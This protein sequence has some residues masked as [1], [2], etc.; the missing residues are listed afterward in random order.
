MDRLKTKKLGSNKDGSLLAF[1]ARPIIFEYRVAEEESNALESV[2]WRLFEQVS[3]N[4]SQS[5][6]N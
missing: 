3:N 2:F 4:Q 5:N 6:A 1:K